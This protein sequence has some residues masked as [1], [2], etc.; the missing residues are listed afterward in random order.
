MAEEREQR[1]AEVAMQYKA[2]CVRAPARPPVRSLCH[3]RPCHDRR[4]V[5]RRQAQ[6]QQIG[7]KL[8]ELEGERSEHAY[9]RC[10]LCTQP[11]FRLLLS[12][13][14]VP[15]HLSLSHARALAPRTPAH[16]AA[17]GWRAPRMHARP[18]SALAAW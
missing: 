14:A 1:M 11:L 3:G 4:V 18:P 9:A 7:Q 5:V 16:T 10:A 15:P 12:S 6:M 13:S 8:A 2:L 17:R